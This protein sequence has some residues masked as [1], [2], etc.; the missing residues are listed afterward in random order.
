MSRKP[1]ADDQSSPKSVTFNSLLADL[2]NPRSLLSLL[3]EDFRLRVLQI[4]D[5]L[6][7]R[8]E[9]EIIEVLRLANIEVSN[10]LEALRNNFW[11]EHDRIMALGKN[12]MMTLANIYQGVCSRTY[13]HKLND[14]HLAYLLTRTADYEAVMGGLQS[15]ALRRIRDVLSIPLQ[16]LDGSFQDPKLIELVLKASAMVDMRTR[17]GYLQRSETKNL[18][19][20]EQRIKS[21]NSYTHV[22]TAASSD[23]TAD[24]ALMSID[25]KIKQLEQEAALLPESSGA[26]IT[27]PAFKPNEVI[28]PVKEASPSTSSQDISEAEYK[29]V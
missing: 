4:P 27:Q 10:T 18:T 7:N 29:E 11:I 21:E 24:F 13:F 26:A 6:L 9:E 25:E 16:K 14:H 28:M 23:K 8:S 22:F 17:G 1:I 12:T 19:L 5:N 3:P 15:L 2:E 20:M